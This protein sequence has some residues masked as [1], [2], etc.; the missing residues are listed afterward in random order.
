MKSLISSVSAVL[1]ALAACSCCVGPL[2]ALAGVLGV[3]AS[4]LIWLSSIKT[5]L[6]VFSLMA[7][8]YNLYRA[9]F[10]KKE[11]ECCKVNQYET[12]SGLNDKE[13]KAVSFFQSKKFLWSIAILTISILLLPHVTN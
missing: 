7:I 5:Y 2:M 13:K 1:T 8:C 11:Q 3:S 4:Q 9:Y 10:P 12:L 6:I